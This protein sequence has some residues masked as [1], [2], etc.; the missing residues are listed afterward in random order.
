MSNFSGIQHTIKDLLAQNG[1]SVR[2]TLEAGMDF[3][4]IIKPH[5]V[6]RENI[7]VYKPRSLPVV[8]CQSII[9]LS[10]TRLEQISNSTIDEQ[11]SLRKSLEVLWNPQKINFF[12]IEDDGTDYRVEIRGNIPVIEFNVE[13]FAIC[14]DNINE[15][16]NTVFE[17]LD[18]FFKELQG[19]G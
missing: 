11:E 16:G 1:Y 12:E 5:D 6:E 8:T 18:K 13:R 10:S 3:H 17:A 7:T 9:R 2:E 14:I 4:M 19:T 15:L